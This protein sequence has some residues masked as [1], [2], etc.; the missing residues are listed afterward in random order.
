MKTDSIAN[1]TNILGRDFPDRLTESPHRVIATKADYP[2][3]LACPFHK[4]TPIQFLYASAGVMT[5]TTPQGVWVVPPFRAV[6][7][8]SETDHSIFALGHLALRSL[9]IRPD[10]IPDLPSQCCVVSVP[11]LLRELILHAAEF[12][13]IY[14][15]NSPE[16]RIMD[17]ILD[18]VQTLDTAPLQ[19]PTPQDERLLKITQ[20]LMQDPADKRTLDEW[21]HRIGATSRT[22]A[23]RFRKETGMSFSQWRQQARLLKALQQLARGESVT[24]VAMSLGYDSV[25][26]FVAMFRKTLGSTPG[27]YFNQRL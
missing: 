20:V 15:H 11:P 24:S 14:L 7:I 26:A 22:L 19:L 8:P 16:E 3:G 2:D 9:Y 23:R 4:H 27:Q 17:V 18:M 12:S 10:A 6:W 13:V 25:S 21:G 1:K 5:V